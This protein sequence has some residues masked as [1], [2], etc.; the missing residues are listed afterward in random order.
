M[1]KKKKKKKKRTRTRT[2]TRRRKERLKKKD[3]KK[4]TMYCKGKERGSSP[5]YKANV[6]FVYFIKQNTTCFCRVFSI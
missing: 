6:L 5:R 2:R 3:S 4:N 1:K